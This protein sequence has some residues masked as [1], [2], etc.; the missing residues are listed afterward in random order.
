VLRACVRPARTT[1][2]SLLRVI[3]SCDRRSIGELQNRQAAISS[4]LCS[5][6]DRKID[7]RVISTEVTSDAPRSAQVMRRALLGQAT[8]ESACLGDARSAQVSSDQLRRAKVWAK[9]GLNR[10]IRTR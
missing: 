3:F 5:A 8:S 10:R 4:L 2:G 7:L 1:I 6:Y 9:V